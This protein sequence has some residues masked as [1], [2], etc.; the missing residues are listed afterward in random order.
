MQRTAFA[1]VV[2]SLLAGVEFASALEMGQSPGPV[3]LTA[4]SG[5]SIVMD[6]YAG[7]PATA[8]LFLSSR[9]DATDQS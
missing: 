8:V 5:E 1:V 3:R 4:L 2:V 7:R 6:H 9:C